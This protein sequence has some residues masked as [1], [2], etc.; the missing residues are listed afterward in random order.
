M[1]LW[2]RSFSTKRITN[3]SYKFIFSEKPSTFVNKLNF[4]RPVRS[5]MIIIFAQLEVLLCLS[6]AYNNKSSDEKLIRSNAL[7]KEVIE[8]FLKN[9]CLNPKNEWSKANEERA[10]RITPGDLRKL[11]N[12]LTHFFS[13]GKELA[14]SYPGKDKLTR[15]TEKETNFKVKFLSPEDLWKIARGAGVLLIKQ[16]SNDYKKSLSANSDD[17][18]QRVLSVKDVIEK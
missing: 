4:N 12:S 15:K 7:K 18:K 8:A 1:D 14:I 10:R 13:T 16:W 11:R 3:E 17:F 5:E 9:F 6:I 2:K